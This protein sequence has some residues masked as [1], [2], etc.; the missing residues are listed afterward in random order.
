NGERYPGEHEPIIDLETW[1]AVQTQL[2]QNAVVRLRQSNAKVPSL[3]AGLLFADD[4]HRL[5][6][7]H[8]T[9]SGRRYRYYVSK[10][11]RLERPW[12]LPALEIEKV[13]LSGL[14]S[15]LND[16][17]RLFADLCL[18]R[19]APEIVE[20]VIKNAADL[21]DRVRDGGSAHQRETFLLII[22]RV[23]VSE[24][25]VRVILKIPTLSALL[26]IPRTKKNSHK[27]GEAPNNT[28]QLDLDIS[29]K[30]RGAGTKLVL[31]NSPAREPEID[32]SLIAA[33]AKGHRWFSEI[34]QRGVQSVSQLSECHGVD[35]TE[36]GRLIPLAFLAPD[37]VEDIL[38]GRQPIDLTVTRL[39]RMADLP[40]SWSEQRKL[41]RFH[42][43][44]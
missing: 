39:K 34:K 31:T 37:I 15:F 27:P 23:E 25:R 43:Q 40:V 44:P 28:L 9:K 30:R 1:N 16:G 18:A 42:P 6:P 19:F 10:K 4:G 3:L 33:V 14:R 35:R 13:V 20:T 11:E 5:S 29:F 17:P 7:S 41:F 24:A 21:A 36:I 26:Q 2:D 38:N 32:I 22:E 12:R 8:A